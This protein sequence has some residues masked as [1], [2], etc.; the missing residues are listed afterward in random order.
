MANKNLNPRCKYAI[1]D[2]CGFWNCINKNRKKKF[3][4]FEWI[5]MCDYYDVVFKTRGCRY[6]EKKDKNVACFY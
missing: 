3:V 4:W 5:P 2:N 6:R 1:G